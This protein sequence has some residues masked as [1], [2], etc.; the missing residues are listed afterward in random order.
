MFIAILIIENR[1][2]HDACKEQMMKLTIV[3][4]IILLSVVLLSGSVYA[5]QAGEGESI[6]SLSN[7]RASTD[8]HYTGKYCSECHEKTPVKGG[9]DFLRF[10]GDFTKLCWC[11]GYTPGTYIHPVDLIPSE[12]KRSVMPKDFPLKEGKLSCTT[13]HD[14]YLQCEENYEFK[15]ANK[16][17][18]R[19]APYEKR[20]DLCFK[21]HDGKKYRKRDPHNDQISANGEID[22]EKCLYCHEEKPDELRASFN[23]V[24]LVGSLLEVCQRCHVKTT[25]HPANAEH[26]VMPSL[27]ILSRIKETERQFNI[28]LPLDYNGRIFCA[29]CHNPHQKGVIPSEN[30]GARGAGEMY[31]QRFPGKMCIACHEK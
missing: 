1:V 23:E 25:R 7:V 18:L 6:N 2:F 8:I 14:I 16:R 20:T 5:R 11:H 10:G 17:F 3:K 29:T 12:E 26:L 28:I 31:G 9:D 21:C 22:E 4:I 19:G 13:C 15:F 30:I 24:R 27:K